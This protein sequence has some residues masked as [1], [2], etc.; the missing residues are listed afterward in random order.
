[1]SNAHIEALSDAFDGGA[2]QSQ[3]KEKKMRMVKSSYSF[4][5]RFKSAIKVPSLKKNAKKVNV[6]APFRSIKTLDLAACSAY[7]FAAVVTNTAV[8]L[9]PVIAA[10]SSV[11]A[12]SG[13]STSASLAITVASRAAMGAALGKFING[14]VCQSVGGRRSTSVYLVAL[15]GFTFFFSTAT[16]VQEIAMANTAMEF[17]S[18]ILWTAFSSIF[19]THY[20]SDGESFAQG[21]TALSLSSTIGAL[22]T[23]IVLSILL[24]VLHWRTVARISSLCALL[25]LA[26]VQLGVTDSRT[27]KVAPQ[28]DSLTIS[29]IKESITAVMGNRLFW[30]V[31]VAHS[32]SYLGRSSDKILG[33]FF[34]EVAKVP[35]YMCGGLTSSVTIGF[36]HGIITG[37]KFHSIDDSR[38]KKNFLRNRYTCN[39]LSALILSLCANKT[40]ASLLGVAPLVATVMIA[41]FTMASSISF[42]FY[43]LPAA[44]S[45]L[46][47]V[48]QAVCISCLDAIGLLLSAPI[49]TVTGRIITY[50]NRTNGWSLAWI[51]LAMWFS[52]GS[53]L[54]MGATPSFLEWKRDKDNGLLGKLVSNVLHFGNKKRTKSLRSVLK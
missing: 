13:T 54:M 47:G 48:N 1:M 38:E 21:M 25:A 10:D 16:S 28:G 33:T 49:W 27:S 50:G 34:H 36:V 52:F 39:I 3:R 42:Q 51:S 4:P 5:T 30:M 37:R 19:A 22:T 26:M 32:M 46:A 8:V 11:V 44:F 17:C 6:N 14:F 18:S 35:A 31:G 29:S 23:K 43:Q 12:S 20:E 9:L 15:T 41:C 7:F 24:K 45:K 2:Q 40:V 53:V